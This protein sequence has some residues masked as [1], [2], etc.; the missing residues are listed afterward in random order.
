VA[1][2]SPTNARYQ[3]QSKKVGSTKRSASSAKPKREAGTGS[4]ERTT[5]KSSGSGKK[6]A[7][8]RPS[9]PTTPRIRRLR[10]ISLG[11]MGVA[12]A[13]ASVVAFV[14]G[15][16]QN[17]TAVMALLGVWTLAFGAAVYIDFGMVRK[18]QKELVAGG[19]PKPK[20]PKPGKGEGTEPAAD[21]GRDD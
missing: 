5:K 16:Q 3:D 18:L 1:R 14:P 9:Q 4:G 21:A 7:S 6:T 13:A 15:M 17:R 20:A 12:L 2:R 10:M 8:S 19:K 11:L